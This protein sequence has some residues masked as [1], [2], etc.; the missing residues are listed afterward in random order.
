M[1]NADLKVRM[2]RFTLG[3]PE[4]IATSVIERSVDVS[5]FL[6]VDKRRWHTYCL[7]GMAKL[8]LKS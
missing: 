3:N 1:P 7:N 5:R 4:F 6:A 2:N 8:T